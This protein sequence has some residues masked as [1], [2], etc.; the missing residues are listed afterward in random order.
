MK[1]EEINIRDPFVLVH[2]GKYYLYDCY[3]LQYLDT[4]AVIANQKKNA[5]QWD[6]FISYLRSKGKL[7][8]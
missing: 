4:E 8:K 5:L 2:D 1:R 6:I 3:P 7:K